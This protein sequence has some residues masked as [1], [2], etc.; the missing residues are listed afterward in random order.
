MADP[1]EIV[2]LLQ[3]QD[4]LGTNERADPGPVAPYRFVFGTTTPISPGHS[5]TVAMT[6]TQGASETA[7]GSPPN[8]FQIVSEVIVGIVNSHSRTSYSLHNVMFD[9]VSIAV[10][11]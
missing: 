9:R 5:V 3:L 4:E 10:G 11:R 2:T 7:S 1:S 6:F 8:F